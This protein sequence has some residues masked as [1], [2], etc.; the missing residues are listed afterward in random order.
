MG[1]RDAV[2]KGV[3]RQRKDLPLCVLLMAVDE[4]VERV[5]VRSLQLDQ[6]TT[7]SDMVEVDVVSMRVVQSIV[8]VM[9]C[10]VNTA[11]DASVSQKG[12][13]KMLSTED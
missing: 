2:I 9:G 13:L 4:G 5:V 8:Q 6:R 10:A 1:V 3:T 12:A 7:A 11:A